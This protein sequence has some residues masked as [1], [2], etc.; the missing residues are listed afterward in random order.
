M[1]ISARAQRK[2]DQG[3]VARIAFHET[4][5][6]SGVARLDLGPWEKWRP[7]G[8]PGVLV[9]IGRSGPVYIN[10]A[11]VARYGADWRRLGTAIQQAVAAAVHE[12]SDRP[13]GRVDVRITDITSGP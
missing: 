6:Q 2:T 3:L 1:G 10:V 12:A 9:R 7:T 11:I 4:L 5:M 8:T 13:V